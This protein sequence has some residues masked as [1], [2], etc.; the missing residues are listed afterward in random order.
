VHALKP[1]AACALAACLLVAGCTDAG[2][3]PDG[4]GTVAP[5]E[6]V[7]IPDDIESL[8]A[9]ELIVRLYET[10]DADL[11]A[12]LVA[13]GSVPDAIRDEVHTSLTGLLDGEVE[14]RD[15]FTH[16]VDG[17]TIEEVDTSDGIRWC[18]RPDR[19]ILLQCRVGLAEITVDTGD[20]PLEVVQA[21][22]DV[23]PEEHQLRLQL[24]PAGD[25]PVQFPGLLT[26]YGEDGDPAPLIQTQAVIANQGEIV[27]QAGRDTAALPGTTLLLGWVT[28]IGEDLDQALQLR[29]DEGAID[30]EVAE[31]T[32]YVR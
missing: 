19:R 26:L 24:R 7:T 2:D 15:T 11:A 5:A 16:E 28:D 31:T 4:E 6:D 12:A 9:E 21:E 1:V 29:W 25:D 14:V 32:W 8:S 10:S 22:V 3:D 13:D 30:L 20:V 23:F 27:S 17:V 18:V